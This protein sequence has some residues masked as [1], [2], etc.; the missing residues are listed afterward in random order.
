[1]SQDLCVIQYKGVPVPC[2]DEYGEGEGDIHIQD[3]ACNGTENSLTSCTYNN[4]VSSNHAQ[5]IGVQCQ[6]GQ[7]N[8]TAIH[9]YTCNH[10]TV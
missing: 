5:D 7:H 6:Q 1:M 9:V 4:T 8:N 3:V 2:C 10:Y